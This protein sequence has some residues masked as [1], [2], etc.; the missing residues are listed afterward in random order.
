MLRS[1]KEL[2]F[3]RAMRKVGDVDFAEI[4]RRLRARAVS[5]MA[6]LDRP[7]PAEPAAPAPPSATPEDR[8]PSCDVRNDAD[9]RFCKSC[10]QRL[11]HA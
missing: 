7:D 6:E 1:I 11:H 5:L 9:A 4:D 8:C 2:E 10:G 3:D